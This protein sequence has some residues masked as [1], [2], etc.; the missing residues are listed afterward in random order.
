VPVTNR[1]DYHIRSWSCCMD[2]SPR[3]THST[4]MLRVIPT[5]LNYILH[6]VHTSLSM[7]WC[8]ILKKVW[9]GKLKTIIQGGPAIPR[10]TGIP[11]HCLLRLTGQRWRYSNPKSKCEASTQAVYRSGMATA[12]KPLGEILIFL[13]LVENVWLSYRYGWWKSSSGTS[14]EILLFRTWIIIFVQIWSEES[15]AHRNLRVLT[16]LHSLTVG[17]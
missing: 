16:S 5:A 17:G 12:R 8:V 6:H 15:L 4:R 1:E 9:F 2:A 3:V 14:L 13:N 10:G 7:R 11:L